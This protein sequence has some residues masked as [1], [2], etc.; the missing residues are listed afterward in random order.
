[1]PSLLPAPR[2]P[3]P[4]CSRCSS[5]A[6]GLREA[7]SQGWWP[8]LRHPQGLLAARPRPVAEPREAPPLQ[9]QGSSQAWAVASH[10]CTQPGRA[11]GSPVARIRPRSQLHT[12]LLACEGTGDTPEAAVSWED[13]HSQWPGGG[14]GAAT[15]SIHTQK[16]LQ[17][18]LSPVSHRLLA[19]CCNTVVCV[20]KASVVPRRLRCRPRGQ[21]GQFS[22]W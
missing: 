22:G 19:C 5:S 14:S 6:L 17:A 10:P 1:M 16:G 9:P 20:A 2:S 21:A 3:T 18:A 12:P 15:C 13:S 8:R 7:L 4:T 11:A